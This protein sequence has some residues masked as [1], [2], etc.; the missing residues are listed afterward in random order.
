MSNVVFVILSTL[1]KLL[2]AV[3]VGV[4][5][6]TGVEWVC[7]QRQKPEQP[8]GFYR[9]PPDQKK[10][11]EKSRGKCGRATNSKRVHRT[12]IISHVLEEQGANLPRVPSKKRNCVVGSQH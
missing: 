2:I 4:C 10:K 8:T 5:V 7:Q 6:A 1:W 3:V 12:S 11:E 9:F